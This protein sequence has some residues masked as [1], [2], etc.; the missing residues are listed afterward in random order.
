MTPGGD[1]SK[2]TGLKVLTGLLEEFECLKR[3]TTDPTAQKDYEIYIRDIG[4]FLQTATLRPLT[5]EEIQIYI[6]DY[7]EVI[8]H[9]KNTL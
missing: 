1:K 2:P 7:S 8:H 6:D 4:K 9:E 3:R 5:A